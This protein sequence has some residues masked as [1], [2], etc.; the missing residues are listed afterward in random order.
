MG[1]V[2]QFKRKE[3]DALDYSSRH[4]YID[5]KGYTTYSRQVAVTKDEFHKVRYE[6]E[7]Q[8]RMPS[9]LMPNSLIDINTS[10]NDNGFAT[11][12]I[13]YLPN[14]YP[15]ALTSRADRIIDNIIINRTRRK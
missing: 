7:E 1:V 5:S 8:L 10:Y 12:I 14:S 11:I 9:I 6:L 2:L 4:I 3:K 15:G 13:V